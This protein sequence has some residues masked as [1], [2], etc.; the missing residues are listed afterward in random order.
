[1]YKILLLVLLKLCINGLSLMATDCKIQIP[2][3]CVKRD[4]NIYIGKTTTFDQIA[5]SIKEGSQ[6][7]FDIDENVHQNM[8]NLRYSFFIK[9]GLFESNI[10]VSRKSIDFKSLV[11]YL[12][13]I[14]Y[15]L[16]FKSFEGFD[17][18]LFKDDE[19]TITTFFKKLHTLNLHEC[20]MRFYIGDKQMKSCQD[21]NDSAMNF[22]TPRS[23]FQLFKNFSLNLM[24]G[25]LTDK[26]CPLA[27]KN[28]FISKLDLRGENSYFSQRLIKFS[29]ETFDDLN[30]TI[31]E[32]EIYIG[33]VE[34]D[35]EFLHPSIFQQTKSIISRKKIKFGS[36]HPDLFLKLKKLK[37]IRFDM[38]EFRSFIHGQGIDWIKN[39][40]K[41]SQINQ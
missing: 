22:T 3:S 4:M 20:L 41:K 8:C 6:I 24:L 18:Q 11:Q 1:M 26:I 32:I 33:N 16:F 29:N 9:P 31:T 14:K 10:K 25:D 13:T 17:L 35:F 21:Y 23:I 39:I 28:V 38:L 19:I 30:T 27:F 34:L 37:T 36:I 40:N 12:S 15:S 5:C 7:R 2:K